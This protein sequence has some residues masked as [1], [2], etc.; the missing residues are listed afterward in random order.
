[1]WSYNFMKISVFSLSVCKFSPNID[2]ISINK[3]LFPIPFQIYSVFL[4][5]PNGIF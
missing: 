2:D 1:M 5:S 3:Q 4:D